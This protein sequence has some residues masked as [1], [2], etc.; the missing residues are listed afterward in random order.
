MLLRALLLG[1]AGASLIASAIAGPENVEFPKDWDKIFILATTR[2]MH[3]GGNT[4]VDIFVNPVGVESGKGEGPLAS[5]T[6]IVMKPYRARLD[7]N[8]QLVYDANGRLI[9]GDPG[10]N[11]TV[12]EKRTGWGVEYGALRNGEWEY[13]AFGLDGERRPVM[14]QSCLECHGALAE[15]DYVFARYEISEIKR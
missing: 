12:M 7:A 15:F 5:G 14:D 10:G 1:A 4:I 9:K 2:D 6:V 11:I 3:R 13:A 8:N